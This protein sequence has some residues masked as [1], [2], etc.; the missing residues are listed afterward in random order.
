MSPRKGRPPIENPKTDRF[1][2]RTTPEEKKEI[3]NFSKQ[4][5]IGLLELLKIGI[6]SVKSKKSSS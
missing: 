6:E 2:I 4:S 5:G 1:N 3:L